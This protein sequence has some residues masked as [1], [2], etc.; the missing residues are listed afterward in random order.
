MKKIFVALVV[1]F[2]A[3]SSVSAQGKV[4]E[5]FEQADAQVQ[6]A[7]AQFPKGKWLDA[8][9]DAMWVFGVNNT[10]EIQDAKTGKSIYVFSKAQR[11]NFK[12]NVSDAGLVITFSCAETNRS[13]KFTK[14]VTLSTD[15]IME[16]DNSVS[17]EHYKVTMK[18]KN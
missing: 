17:G 11:K 10:I 9:W 5:A 13:Y 6:D 18:N 3:L 14:P 4:K 15:I 2:V 8:N 1:A 7:A 12:I 16:I